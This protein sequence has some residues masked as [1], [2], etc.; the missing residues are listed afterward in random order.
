MI[1]NTEKKV[2]KNRERRVEQK[3]EMDDKKK[4]LL[5][6]LNLKRKSKTNFSIKLKNYKLN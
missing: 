5:N 3:I 2:S 6:K 4:L 1:M